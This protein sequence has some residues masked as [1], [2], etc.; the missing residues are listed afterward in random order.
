MVAYT[1]NLSTQEAK[2][3]SLKFEVTLNYIVRPCL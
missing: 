3:E 1:C 2:T